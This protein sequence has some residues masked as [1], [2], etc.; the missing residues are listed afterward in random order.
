MRLSRASAGITDDADLVCAAI[1]ASS[2]RS[3]LSDELRRHQVAPV[4]RLTSCAKAAGL[5]PTILAASPDHK[6]TAALISHVAFETVPHLA[7][8]VRRAVAPDDIGSVLD[9]VDERLL[10]RS[11]CDAEASVRSLQKERD[12]MR[13]LLGRR[14]VHR[15]VVAENLR[16]MKAPLWRRVASSLRHTALGD[17]L[18]S[19]PPVRR[20]MERLDTAPR[21]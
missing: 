3:S 12:E 8:D 10:W 2:D 15:A 7:R 20:L 14:P 16:D 5:E 18:V 11:L 13:E 4:D 21:G 1:E 9:V 6:M 19:T 17:L